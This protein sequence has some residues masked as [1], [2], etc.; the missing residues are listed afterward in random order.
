[1]DKIDLLPQVE[2]VK[3]KG[4]EVLYLTEG[5]DEF[6]MQVLMQYKEKKLVNVS[7]SE[8]DLDSKEEKEALEY[9]KSKCIPRT[10][11]AIS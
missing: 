7:T 1:M 11:S 4:F 10:V 5:I 2:A 3:D 8:L 6:V 9:E